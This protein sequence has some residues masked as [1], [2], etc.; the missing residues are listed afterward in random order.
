MRTRILS[1]VIVGRVAIGCSKKPATT[2]TGLCAG[3]KQPCV[4]F[5]AG[6]TE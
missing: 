6:A 1:L 4:L 5:M 2:A 3:I